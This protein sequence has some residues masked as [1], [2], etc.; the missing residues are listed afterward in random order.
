M[1]QKQPFLERVRNSS[2]VE[3]ACADNVTGL[4]MIPKPRDP[5]QGWIGRGAFH[6]LKK[7]YLR[8]VLEEM[9]ERMQV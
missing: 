5:P 7:E 4:S 6:R 1:A 3:H 8:G 9:E 2:L